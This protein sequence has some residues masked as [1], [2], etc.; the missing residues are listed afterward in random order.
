MPVMRYRPCDHDSRVIIMM[1]GATTTVFGTGTQLCG[2]C[3]SAW[4]LGS[5]THGITDDPG[6]GAPTTRARVP[7]LAAGGPQAELPC[8]TEGRG[9]PGRYSG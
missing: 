9:G 8:Q 6:P 7:G 1:C 5:D 2:W 4:H 3:K